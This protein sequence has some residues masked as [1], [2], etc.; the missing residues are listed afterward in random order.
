[1][2]IND[3]GFRQGYGVFET[4]RGYSGRVFRLESHLERMQAGAAYL[5]IAVDM[6]TVKNAV[7]QT[8][9]ASG[10][11]S[12]RVRPVI[13]AGYGG[14]VTVSVT[15]EN[16]QPPKAADYQNGLRATV[17]DMRRYSK[18][19]LY[20]Y[21][22]LNQ[23]ENTLAAAEADRQGADEAILLNENG[24]V[25]ETNRGN[26][27]LFKD[28]VLRTPDPEAGI[29][30]GITRVTILEIART[31]GIRTIE[32]RITLKDLTNAD[33][34][35]ITS[36]LIE[37]MPLTSIGGTVVTNGKAGTITAELHR[38]YRSTVSASLT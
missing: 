22:T 25:A 36:S 35:F 6:T 9:Q 37:V 1:V 33:E 19:P 28:G 29:L 7:G 34:V 16:Y 27:F 18:S 3:A 31:L 30:P 11:P 38:A 12:A 4:L 23:I 21:K 2:G 10:L 32:G 20:R 8:L 5:G 15:V 14:R 24:E 26:I 13:T 17:V